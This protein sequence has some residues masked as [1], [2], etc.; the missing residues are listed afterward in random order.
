MQDYMRIEDFSVMTFGAFRHI[1]TQIIVEMGTSLWYK[2][3]CMRW[4]SICCARSSSNS[5]AR[6]GLLII[7]TSEIFEEMPSLCA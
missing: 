2:G 1:G 6:Y 3:A 5:N 7:A 4:Y